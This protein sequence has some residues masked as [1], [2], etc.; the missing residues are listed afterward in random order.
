MIIKG[1]A[2]WGVRQPNFGGDVL[3][4]IFTQPR[5]GSAC[6]V[7][8]RV[9]LPGIGSSISPFLD[10]GKYYLFQTPNVGLCVKSETI[11]EDKWKH[12]IT[13][14]SDNPKHSDVDWVFGFHHYCYILWRQTKLTVVLWVDHLILAEIFLIWEKPKHIQLEGKLELVQKLCNAV[15]S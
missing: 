1:I 6:V 5:L 2:I 7:C 4:E 11:W 8:H 14:V 3:A 12:T 15:F 9:L 10:L 13:I